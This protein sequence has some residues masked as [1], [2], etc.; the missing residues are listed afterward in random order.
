M[1]GMGWSRDGQIHSE[2]DSESNLNQ[3]MR[4]RDVIVNSP[5]RDS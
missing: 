3:R 5:G 2:S 1:N 4:M